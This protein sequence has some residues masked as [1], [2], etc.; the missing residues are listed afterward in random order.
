[1]RSLSGLEERTEANG[2]AIDAGREIFAANCVSC[3]GEDAK[4]KTD[5][6]AP[7]L[8]DHFWING[9]SRDAIYHTVFYGRQGH[10]PSWGL[11]LSPLDIKILALYLNDLR[12]QQHAAVEIGRAHV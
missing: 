7:D 9:S 5:V 10:M 12:E 2:A 3:H 1:M 8:T 4:G 6:G 11:R